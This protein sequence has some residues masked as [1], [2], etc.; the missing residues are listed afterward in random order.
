MMLQ[1]TLVKNVKVTNVQADE[2]W[3]FVGMK[4][5]T[6]NDY[7]LGENEKVGSFLYFHRD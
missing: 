3:S 1:E 4:Q 7:G 5:K 6:A 2:I